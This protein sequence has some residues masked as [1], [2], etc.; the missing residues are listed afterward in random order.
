M[1]WKWDNGNLV[2]NFHLVP[3]LI[4]FTFSEIP[5]PTDESTLDTLTTEKDTDEGTDITDANTEYEES[6]EN[7][8]KEERK[9]LKDSSSNSFRYLKSSSLANLGQI[10]AEENF[11]PPLE[12]DRHSKSKPSTM[13]RKK[14]KGVYVSIIP[15][16]NLKVCSRS[17]FLHF[18]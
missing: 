16:A 5:V 13:K 9:E 10:D 3:A 1:Y 7:P 11:S 12:K 4:F 2:G 8:E 15:N 14:R 6:S 18:H 17:S